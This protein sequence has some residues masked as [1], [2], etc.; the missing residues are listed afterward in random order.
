[1]RRDLFVYISG[2]MT[3]KDGRTVEQNVADGVAAYLD[4]IRRGIPA[5]SPHLCGGFPSAWSAVP[6]ETWLDYDYAVIDR[7]THVLMMPRWE[8]S[9]GAVEECRYAR[10]RGVPVVFS[11]DE[12]PGCARG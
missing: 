7:C 2:P 8:T 11:V 12:L 5:F 6:W 1:M 4:C 9:A 3:A 10:E